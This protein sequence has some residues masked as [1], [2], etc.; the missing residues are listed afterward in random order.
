LIMPRNDEDSLR[1]GD[2]AHIVT[3]VRLG[4][5]RDTAWKPM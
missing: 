5:G 3:T 1:S 2:W 4:T